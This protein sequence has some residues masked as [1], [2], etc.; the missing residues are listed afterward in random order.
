[1]LWHPLVIGRID[2]SELIDAVN[3]GKI[4]SKA[5]YRDT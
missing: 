4:L 1:M 3:G 5:A 2:G